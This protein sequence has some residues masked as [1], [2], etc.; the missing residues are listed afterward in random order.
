[1]PEI[2]TLKKQLAAAK[3]EIETLTMRLGNLEI[4]YLTLLRETEEK[5]ARTS[6][7][8]Q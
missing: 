3:A 7:P 5:K 6:L 4:L 1:M 2:E 8:P